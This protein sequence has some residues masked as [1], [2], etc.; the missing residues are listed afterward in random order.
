M[1]FYPRG[2]PCWTAVSH[3]SKGHRRKPWPCLCVCL[4]PQHTTYGLWQES[5]AAGLPGDMPLGLRMEGQGVHE[6]QPPR[7]WELSGGLGLPGWV[8]L[9]AEA[10][11]AELVVGFAEKRVWHL[12]RWNGIAGRGREQ[13]VAQGLLFT[14]PRYC[15]FCCPL[16]W[17]PARETSMPSH[18]PLPTPTGE[19][20]PPPSTRIE[21]GETC[22]RVTF[23]P[24][25]KDQAAFSSSGIMADF[26]VQYDVVMEDI[27]G[28][29]QVRGQGGGASMSSGVT[30]VG[31]TAWLI[32]FSPGISED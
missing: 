7:A 29:V 15:S 14:L 20:G 31:A 32:S 10:E 26:V 2:E 30:Q 27:I 13:Q 28:D 11:Q 19:A 4:S 17:L 23:C 25:L 9:L 1:K 3:S 6:G 8:G 22:V 21:K 16:A 5:Q 12:G 18:P 24:T